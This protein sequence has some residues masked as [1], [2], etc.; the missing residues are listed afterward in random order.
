MTANVLHPGL[1]STGFGGDDPGRA[2]R[3][4]VPLLRPFMKSPRQGAATSIHVASDPDLHHI[5][6]RYFA[7]C[8]SKRSSA[9]SYD[10]SAATRL[11]QASTDLVGLTTPATA[12]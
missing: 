2:Q 7:K 10:E 12:S 11:W 8:E 3:M 6:G 1:V 4:L 5:S 9:G